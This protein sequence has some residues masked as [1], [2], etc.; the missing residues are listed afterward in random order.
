MK[1]EHKE[2][3]KK[4]HKEMSIN[5][6]YDYFKN[7]YTKKQIKNFC[8]YNN[9]KYR[10]LS[11]KERSVSAKN[12]IM[13]KQRQQTPINHDFFKNWSRNMA[14]IFGLWC[15]DGNMG[16]Q[17]KGYQ[18]SIKLHKNDKYLLQ[19][20]LNEMQ[21]EHKI[22]DKKDNSCEF[23]IGSKTIYHDIAKLGGKE[24]KSLDL[25]FPNVPK[26]YLAD[27]IRGYFDGDGTIFKNRFAYTILGTK[28]FLIDVAEI[29]K[30]NNIEISNI[31]QHHPEFGESN[32]C[33]KLGI[34]KKHQANKFANFIYK[35]L[36]DTL[37]LKR[38]Y[39]IFQDKTI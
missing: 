17:N 35:D 37:F 13:V 9:L 34:Y 32:N 5:D 19:S 23:I 29:L 27:F 22:Y 12:R 11:K 33:Y 14:Y 30:E 25:K 26:E 18:F 31:K 3:I 16:R 6:F 15:A 38:K 1:I 4:H 2:F 21:S 28:E 7:K 8:N 39:N 24:R 10:T 36:D 20:I